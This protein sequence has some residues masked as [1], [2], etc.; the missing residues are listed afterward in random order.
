[1]HELFPTLRICASALSDIACAMPLGLLLN[2]LWLGETEIGT[3]R[4]HACLRVCSIVLLVA[5]PLQLLLLSASMTGDDS[6]RAAWISLPD[7]AA[8]HSGRALIVGFCFVAAL[9]IFCLFRSALTNAR[10]V[11][12]G[13]A[14]V[15]GVLASRSFYGHA[16]SDGDFTFREGVQ[17]LHLTSISAWGGGIVVAGLVTLPHATN[18]AEPDEVIRFGRRLSRTVTV[19]LCVVILSG[20]YNSWKGLGGSLSH[21]TDSSWGRMLVLKVSFVLLALCHGVRVRFLLNKEPKR[22]NLSTLI[23]RWIRI[24]A[25]LMLIVFICSAW[26]ANLPPADM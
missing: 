26:L 19:A 4:L 15:L 8:T 11:S 24:E 23:R 18:V 2:R 9:V 7:V 20:L 12:A 6:W 25:V 10:W 21:V 13:I 3:E 17:F 22:S 14:I 5:G 1:M 16:A